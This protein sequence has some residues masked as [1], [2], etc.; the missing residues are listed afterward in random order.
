MK[1]PRIL[2]L[3]TLPALINFAACSGTEDDPATADREDF[4]PPADLHTVT[5]DGEIELRWTGSNVEDDFQG[6]YVFVSTESLETLQGKVVYPN[7]SVNVGV[8]GIPRC[9]DNSAF[10]QAFGLGESDDSCD[11]ADEDNPAEEEASELMLQDEETLTGWVKCY[12]ENAAVIDSKPSVA[13][14]SSL[15]TQSCRVRALSDGTALANGTVYS[16]L[17]VGVLGDD[18]DELSWSSNVVVD[19]PS[20]TAYTGTPSLTQATYLKFTIDPATGVATA[21]TEAPLACTNNAEACTLGGTN[22]GGTAG[23][24]AFFIAR[25]SGST[26]PQRHYISVSSTSNVA[27]QPRGP[28]TFDPVANTKSSRIPR[29]TPA[30]IFATAGIKYP[31]YNNQIF[32]IGIKNSSGGIDYYGKI[33]VG[34]ITYEGGVATGASTIAM[35]V[36]LQTGVGLQYYLQ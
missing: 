1:L 24:N 23:E 8:T 11:G 28:Q 3:L 34:D 10:F 31:M 35:D 14:T 36:I 17:V 9:E 30:S 12:D 27:I 16:F 4:N 32:D 19:A 21:A 15:G 29:D 13:T 2:L 22:A 6:Y 25:D 26:Y 33:Y 18:L 7:T 20:K 5:R